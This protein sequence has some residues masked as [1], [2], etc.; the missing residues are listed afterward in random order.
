MIKINCNQLFSN[1][2]L[3]LC[4]IGRID[5]AIIDCNQMIRINK[6]DGNAYFNCCIEH[7]EKRIRNKQALN[8]NKK[9]EINSIYSR[10]LI[11][12][13]EILIKCQVYYFGESK[14]KQ[15]KT[16]FLVYKYVQVILLISQQLEI[17]IIKIFNIKK[18]VTWRSSQTELID[19][20]ICF[21]KLQLQ[22]LEE[23]ECDIIKAKKQISLLPNSSAQDQ[24]Q[25]N[26]YFERVERI[27]R[28]VT[29]IVLP[30]NETQRPEMQQ[31]MI[32]QF[33]NIQQ[34]LK[35]LQKQFQKQNEVINRIQN[36]DNIQIEFMMEEL[37]KPKNK[38]I[39]LL[40]ACFRK[41]QKINFKQIKMPL[42]KVLQKKVLSLIQ[43]SLKAGSKNLELLPIIGGAFN[44]INSV[45]DYGVEYQK[46]AKFKSRIILLINIM[47]IFAATLT[48]LEKEIQFAA[49]KLSKFEEPG[50]REIQISKFI[51][52]VEKLSLLENSSEQYSRDPY[53]KKGTA[54]SLKL[55][56]YLEENND[57]IIIEDQ[58][59]KLRQILIDA[60]LKNYNSISNKMNKSE[61][62][63]SKNKEDNNKC[64]IQ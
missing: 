33:Q 50:L 53:W 40:Y 64:N 61:N 14:K 51:Q 11:N 22:I 60:L 35:E 4:D 9:I 7:F 23:I 47:K 56:K 45:L 2:A 63:T 6:N 55:Q 13:S 44:I 18:N 57:M 15:K 43:N 32:K 59:K 46:E 17:C 54:D 19:R 42:L 37:K 30:N 58:D 3:L 36:L 38:Q 52:F 62:K 26:E 48:E 10:A 25:V 34:Q 21:I 8:Y 27:E 16:V 24:N 31:N 20:Y 12:R 28:S 49:I 29:V 39:L 1:L 41:F 5:R